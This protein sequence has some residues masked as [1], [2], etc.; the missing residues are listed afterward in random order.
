[1]NELGLNLLWLAGQV[2]LLCLVAIVTLTLIGRRAIANLTTSWL[3][4]LLIL[5]LSLM[6]LSP[7]PRWSWESE[8][9]AET[10][11]PHSRAVGTSEPGTT[12]P[13]SSTTEPGSSETAIPQVEMK[14]VW[15]A[16]MDGLIAG[17][18]RAE[19][20]G[21]PP[22]TTESLSWS[23]WLAVIAAVVLSLG[24]LR[25]IFGWLIVR[26]TV[27]KSDRI[28]QVE[29]RD[30]L[31]I[32]RA[33]LSC[34]QR[35]QLRS[36]ADVGAPATTG[37][38][39]PVI[40]LP[41]DWEDWSV[42]QLRTVLAHEVAH[43]LNAD[44]WKWLV[45]QTS[46]LLNFYHPLVHLLV[47]RLRLEQELAADAVAAPAV[48]GPQRYLETLAELAVR[49]PSQ[50]QA[51][52]AQA[53]LP[54]SGTLL[55]RIEMLRD[56]SASHG[57]NAWKFSCVAV[58]LMAAV[59]VVGLR[60]PVVASESAVAA[61][62]QGTA[63]IQ[64]DASYPVQFLPHNAAVVVG[65]QPSQL[66]SQA[67]LKPLKG[68]IEKQLA[69]SDI[70]IEVSDLS[71]MMIVAPSEDSG[72]S[73][74]GPGAPVILITAAA[75]VNEAAFTGELS[76]FG[77]VVRKESVP[78]GTS[79]VVVPVGSR[80]FAIGPARSVLSILE[81][82]DQNR[83][84][85]IESFGRADGQV[86]FAMDPAFIRP[87]LQ[88]SLKHQPNPIA[89]MVSPLWQ[90]P[91]LVTASLS[92]GK[93]MKLEVKAM[94]T[95]EEGAVKVKTAIDA[96]LPLGKAML[97]AA[98]G[99]LASAPESQKQIIERSVK[100]A[101][102]ALDNTQITRQGTTVTLKQTSDSETVSSLTAMMMPAIQSA[103]DAARVAQG[104]NNLKQILLA[105]HNYHSVYG[106][107]PPQYLL[108]PDGKTKHSW[109][110]AILPFL[111]QQELYE[112]YQLDEPWDS[113]ANRKVLGQMPLVY[114]SPFWNAGETRTA[115]FGLVGVNTGL[116]E[117]PDKG[118]AG[119]RI[120]D[121][122]DGT[123]NTILIVEAD[124]QIPWTK[125]EDIPLEDGKVPPLGLEGMEYF[126]AAMCDGSVRR[127]SDS[128]DQENLLWYLTKNDGRVVEP[129]E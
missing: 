57:R 115:Y 126:L 108:G 81:K 77:E 5:G 94:T 88:E 26:N 69:E 120:R 17:F 113:E 62:S 110:V 52:P 122:L 103:R 44:S 61:A 9:M 51:W 112:Q 58:L 59:G 104:K 27:R 31:D 55:R 7:W 20:V 22:P 97:G 24:L 39:R 41:P 74:P 121:F 14:S 8:F 25:F 28:T 18:G 98:Q 37:W 47:R 79:L 63:N 56:H 82:L 3:S 36:S 127:I 109:R 114:A 95:S 30:L 111:E 102:T 93:T 4:V 53:F 49:R 10:G 32:V 29:A 42:S 15:A 107:F 43:V 50:N 128:T 64:K 92:V 19:A 60:R 16:A 96:L 75:T 70:N 100:M 73:R 129:L 87:Q 46:L 34:R 117:G 33:E 90:E 67:S 13:G 23:G 2:T 48:G 1:M 45:A 12:E 78:E 80:T 86:H 40:L 123:S 11:A 119:E 116:G 83:P 106:H 105:F 89:F 65:F 54:T 125:P 35:I 85:W 68:L 118:N 72:V 84:S 99:Q 71:S 38:I 76:H 91:A 124:R 101:S 21:P 6:S 66:A